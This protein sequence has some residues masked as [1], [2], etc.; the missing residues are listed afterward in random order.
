MTPKFA[1]PHSSWLNFGLA[2]Q[3]EIDIWIHPRYGKRIGV[4]TYYGATDTF[5]VETTRL[6]GKGRMYKTLVGYDTPEWG[7]WKKLQRKSHV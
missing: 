6:D 7:M 2:K 5:V 1:A 3:S 4:W